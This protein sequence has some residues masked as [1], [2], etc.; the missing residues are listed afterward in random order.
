MELQHKVVWI[1]GASSGIGAALVKAMYAQ[2]C[3]IV[4]S[5]R[6]VA[7]LEALVQHLSI[8]TDQYLIVPADMEKAEEEAEQWTQAVL[9]KFGR[10]D[11]LINNAGI[12]HKSRVVE[13]QAAVERKV[14]EINFF[15]LAALTKAVAK[16][17]QQQKSGM[18]V[19]I[20][21]LLGDFGLPNV[22]A[23]CASKHAL[24]GYYE[25]LRYE[26]AADKVQVLL[27]APGFINTDITL[28]S[29]DKNGKAYQKNS[30]AQEKGMPPDKCAR[31]IVSAI[32]KEKK[33]VYVGGVETYFRW[34]NFYT[35]SLFRYLM[36]KLHKL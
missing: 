14:M 30:K 24:N 18:L 29:L 17:M 15:G 27:I 7:R 10:I 25:S 2:N 4:L 8:S 36:K 20:S 16:Q 11:V 32:R 22:G 5:A 33:K 12:A 9:E 3:K 1:T 19:G 35:P 26:L 28:N 31:K 13:T 23:Y 21:S 6:R 34:V